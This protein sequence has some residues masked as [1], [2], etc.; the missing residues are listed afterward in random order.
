MKLNK[1]RALH[2]GHSNPMQSYR[3][4]EEWQERCLLEKD[5]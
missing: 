1:C 2:L 5:L 3:L 4:R